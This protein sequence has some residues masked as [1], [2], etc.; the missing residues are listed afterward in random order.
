MYQ[1]TP[2]DTIHS[3]QYTAVYEKLIV[4]IEREIT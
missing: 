4:K 2:T 1:V 3:V